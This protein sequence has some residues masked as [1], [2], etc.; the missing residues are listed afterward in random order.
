MKTKLVVSA[1]AVLIGGASL[2]FAS[3]AFA[4]DG[5]TDNTAAVDAQANDGVCAGLDSGKIDVT[6]K[7]VYEVTITAPAGNLITGY[8]IKAGSINSGNG[9]VNEVVNPPVASLTIRYKD[10]VKEISHYSYSWAPIA[11]P[12]PTPTP[13]PTPTPTTPPAGGGGDGGATL[14]ETGFEAG[15]LTFAGLGVLALGAALVMPRLVAKRR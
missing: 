15:W 5:I 6:E 2:L 12:T 11:T 7:G 14:A 10:G 3:P 8:C 1:A 9:P 4:D 13:E